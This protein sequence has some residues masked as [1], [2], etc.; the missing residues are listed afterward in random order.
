MRSFVPSLFIDG[1]WVAA[2]D[3]ACSQVINP[4]DATVVAEV[5]VA[6]D[7]QV[8]AA[9]A[10]ARRAF[11]ATDWPRTPT[12]DRAALLDRVAALLDRDQEELARLETA[13]S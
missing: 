8:Q 12:A 6:T 4:S 7:D 5:D 13:G 10:A 3:G 1:V 9:I 11:D 2:G